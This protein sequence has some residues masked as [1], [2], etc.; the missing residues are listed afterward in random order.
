MTATDTPKPEALEVMTS[1]LRWL[2]T[3]HIGRG[4]YPLQVVQRVA[5][6]AARGEPWEHIPT[7]WRARPKE[8]QR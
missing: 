1:A 2:S 6:A 3:V 5:S 4:G 7:A 8:R